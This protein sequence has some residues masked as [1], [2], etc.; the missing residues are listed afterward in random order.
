VQIEGLF[1]DDYW[2]YDA[3]LIWTSESGILSAGLYGKNLSDEV[4][5]TDGQE[6]SSVGN[7]RTVYYGAPRTVSLVLTARY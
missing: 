3:S 4:Y 7:I 5:R 2:L 6:F 1:Q